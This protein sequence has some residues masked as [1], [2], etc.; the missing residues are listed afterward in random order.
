MEVFKG[1]ME[2][3]GSNFIIPLFQY[4]IGPGFV[5]LAGKASIGIIHALER[6]KLIELDD[7]EEA[8]VRNVIVGAVTHTNQTMVD[9][10]KKKRRKGKLSLRD[11]ADSMKMTLKD[12]KEDLKQ[13]GTKKA[14]A[15]LDAGTAGEKVIRKKVE[16]ALAAGLKSNPKA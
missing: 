13:L 7:A 12:V 16:E 11:V 8:Q 3:I 6:K 15:L 14:M 9:N 10:L 5:L 1:I 2:A 4:V